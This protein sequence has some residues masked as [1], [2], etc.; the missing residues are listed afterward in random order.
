MSR[1]PQVSRLQ[2][3]IA[4]PGSKSH[5]IRALLIAAMAGGDGES[6]LLS[7]LISHDTLSAR[8]MIEQFGAVVTEER[9]PAPASP[10][11]ERQEVEPLPDLLWKV[12]GISPDKFSIESDQVIEIDVGNSGTSL[13]LGSAVAALFCRPVRFD[14]DASIRKRS[15]KNLLCA[16]QDLGVD[17]RSEGRD[18]SCPYT[19][20]GPIR[21][22][23][24]NLA[25]P[26][27]QYLSALLLALPLTA[28]DCHTEV[29]LD[30]LNEHPYV[31]ITLEWLKQQGIQW[32]NEDYDHYRI[33]GGQRYRPF[34][35][36][37]PADFSS[38]T[39]FFC[40]AAITGSTIRLRGLDPNDTQGD[41]QTLDFLQRMGC[42][43]SW[44]QGPQES[45]ESQGPGR[46]ERL[47]Q[48]SS[49]EE[50]E[51]NYTL[52]FSGPDKL[53][54]ADL[55]L[56]RTPDALPAMAVACACAAG[57]S[58][59]YNVAHARKKE[60]DRIRCMAEELQ[61]LG[62]SVTENPDGLT[63]RGD[64]AEFLRAPRMRVAHGHH[65]HRLIMA[66]SLLNLLAPKD[67]VIL[68]DTAYA[69]VTFPGFFENLAYL[70]GRT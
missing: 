51:G 18:F 23:S 11:G 52:E 60:T 32:Q 43:Y 70:S 3:E 17:V 55:D 15:A 46:I 56:G 63:I 22:G 25:A 59:I 58:K 10:N 16:L 41:K 29:S 39:F 37:M 19:V 2:G 64:T 69:A 12:R 13:Y 44:F 8:S 28:K 36:L 24:I 42:K 14:G 7:P 4:V 38:A 66:L 35:R 1:L 57:T 62:F 27:S 31:D 6:V 68:D 54:A 61:T 53:Q 33:P 34:R 5:T 26:T 9:R 47:A 67:P 49:C 21:G 30:L 45:Q 65:D 40:A 20:R 48:D 50:A